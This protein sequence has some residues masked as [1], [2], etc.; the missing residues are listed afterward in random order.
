MSE[1]E[2]RVVTAA[3]DYRDASDGQPERMSGYAAMFETEAVIGGLFREV[4]RP[5]AFDAAVG[6]DDVRALFNHDPNYVLGRTLAGTMTL[7]V[8][9]KGLR[10]NRPR[11]W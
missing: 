5:G 9:A 1:T 8:D 11:K 3:I 10:C 4:V 6:R 2:R 7:S